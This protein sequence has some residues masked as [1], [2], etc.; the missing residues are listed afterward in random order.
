MSDS[1]QWAIL[2]PAILLTVLGLIQVGIW[3]HGRTVASNAAIAG[4]EEASMLGATPARARTV[5]QIVAADGGLKDV[6]VTVART[7]TTARVTVR[8]RTPS[9]VNLGQEAVEGGATRP[10]ERVTQP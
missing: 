5:A 2:T 9:F 8:G 1:V 10:V 3:M 7:A 4:A 6:R